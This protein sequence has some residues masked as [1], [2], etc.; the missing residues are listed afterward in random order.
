[1]YELLRTSV[2]MN[3]ECNSLTNYNGLSA[4]RIVNH[5]TDTVGDSVSSFNQLPY[6]NSL[7]DVATFRAGVCSSTS[8]PDLV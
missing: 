2:A 1:M 5:C 8:K 4:S 6:S 7:L 3:Y